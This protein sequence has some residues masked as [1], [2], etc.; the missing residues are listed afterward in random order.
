MTAREALVILRRRWWLVVGL[1]LAVVA[2][3]MAVTRPEPV[4]YEA[5]LRFA[6]DIPR[7]ALLPGSDEGTAAKIGEALID[8]IAR[9]IP[10]E[11]FAAAVAAR[12]PE[13]AHV[14]A[15]ELA[16]ELS[17][18]D[19][20]RVADVWVRRAVA[21]DAPEAERR[22]MAEDLQ[23]VAAA[24]VTELEERGPVWFARLGEDRV[25]LTVVDG[26][27][28]RALP[29]SLQQRLELP[30]RAALALVVAVGLAFLLHAI[31][32]RLY[33]AEEAAEACGAPVIGRLH[34]PRRRLW[35]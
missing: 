8:D 31:D 14:A 6:V 33:A 19:R 3:T 15:G 22:A 30:L 27:G 35:R 4:V 24:A 17:A 20:H 26:P 7:S 28:V 25:A 32:P 5:R 12:L 29:P 1:P 23:A 10:S 16:S 2:T 13:D 21:A 18:T 34:A 11:A 9:I